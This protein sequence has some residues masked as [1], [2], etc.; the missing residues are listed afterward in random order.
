MR[1]LFIRCTFVFALITIDLLLSAASFAATLLVDAIGGAD[2]LARAR[3]L[4]ITAMGEHFVLSESHLPD[5]GTLTGGSY[6]STST[7]DLKADRLRTDYQRNV[8]FNFWE[9]RPNPRHVYSEIIDGRRGY[10]TGTDNILGFGDRPMFPDRVAATR[11]HQRLL[12]PHLVFSE[13]SRGA[14]TIQKT[15]TIRR[16]G[17]TYRNITV[18]DRIAPITYWINQ[19]SGRIDRMTTRE[20]RPDQRDVDLDVRY[21]HWV[22][23][24]G[25][26][27]PEEVRILVS[28]VLVE[29]EVRKIEAPAEV[30][31]AVFAIPVDAVEKF[32]QLAETPQG[33]FIQ[34]WYGTP[35]MEFERVIRDDPTGARFGE[36]HSQFLRTFTAIGV[37]F[38]SRHQLV[39]PMELAPGVHLLLGASNNSLVVEQDKGVVVIEAPLSPER[40]KAILAWIAKTYPGKPVTHAVA[41]HF[42]YDH[43]AGLRQFMHNGSTIVSSEISAPYLAGLG[44]MRSAVVPDDLAKSGRRPKTETIASGATKTLESGK[45][46]IML[47]HAAN[48]HAADW[49]YAFLPQ[50]GVL[51]TADVH[52][53]P[54]PPLSQ[55]EF[56]DF[57]ADVTKRNLPIR[58][59]AGGHGATQTRAEFDKLL[60]E[61]AVK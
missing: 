49:T 57:A 11:K 54:F 1:K 13:I 5:S 22:N 43:V 37:A 53:P 47:I 31:D 4:K 55:S 26:A 34:S 41:T 36:A 27:A 38:N 14:R 28:G 3:F 58:V 8:S 23:A 45:N 24:G 48:R 7:I 25:V 2:A 33:A 61:I 35:A 40:S 12:N 6:R 9:Q 59:V 17:V 15:V 21:S 42:H 30:A 29:H 46:A 18:S 50:S 44:A 51:F 19:Q 20:S 39:Q 52:S 32:R 10:V 56:A 60:A 16:D